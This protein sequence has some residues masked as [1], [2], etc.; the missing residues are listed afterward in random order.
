ME[1]M[2]IMNKGILPRKVHQ[3]LG[4][5]RKI[6]WIQMTNKKEVS[7]RTELLVA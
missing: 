5:H 1:E 3:M 6:S 4:N 2:I 7:N